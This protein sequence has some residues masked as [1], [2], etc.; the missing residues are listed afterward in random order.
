MTKKEE[1]YAI[2]DLMATGKLF[3]KVLSVL[4]KAFSAYGRA[5]TDETISIKQEWVEFG[6]KNNAR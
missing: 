6:N 2:Q 5:E 3:E 4:D 1:L